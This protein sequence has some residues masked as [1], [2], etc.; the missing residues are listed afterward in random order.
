MAEIGA[1]GRDRN[2]AL[3]LAEALTE[4]EMGVLRLVAQGMSNS[5][6]AEKL[7]GTERTVKAHVNSLLNK[8]GSSGI[9][10]K[11]MKERSH[12]WR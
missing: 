11:L 7:V 2:Q 1:P 10:G 8:L 6:T 5:E 9:N 4:R 3:K 12:T